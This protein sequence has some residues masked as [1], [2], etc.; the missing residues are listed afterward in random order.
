MSLANILTYEGGKEFGLFC[1]GIDVDRTLIIRNP[2]PVAGTPIGLAISEE[3]GIVGTYSIGPPGSI[4][5]APVGSS[6]NDN[7]ATITGS[8]LNLQPADATHPGV[9][10]TTAQ[11]LAGD[12]TF[13]D[14]V[15]VDGTTTLNGITKL[16]STT[17]YPLNSDTDEATILCLATEGSNLD[18][19]FKSPITLFLDTS[20]GEGRQIINFNE[21][22]QLRCNLEGSNLNGP[23]SPVY[24]DYD[25]NNLQVGF[26]LQYVMNAA[27][28]G[29]VMTTN[30]SLLGLNSSV[31]YDPPS[32]ADL[33]FNL[34]TVST[35]VPN[36]ID[37]PLGNMPNAN[38]LIRLELPFTA[39]PTEYTVE[40]KVSG[41]LAG[42]YTTINKTSGITGSGSGTNTAV[43]SAVFEYYY[44]YVNTGFDT[45]L[46]L[47]VGA[48]SFPVPGTARTLSSAG[49]LQIWVQTQQ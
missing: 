4:S 49:K 25:N 6:P 36:T 34:L 21:D 24:Q 47:W 42:T 39:G 26:H 12:K 29:G 10:S 22:Y 16:T 7:A 31:T 13:Q 48:D 28:T 2:L 8:I 27:V 15:S 38:F 40:L 18:Q 23:F 5:L 11:T 19:V 44:T 43:G 1:G 30:T 17:T 37:I 41:T 35:I 3:D 20:V 9:V 46:Q 14:D 45:G 33:P 32:T